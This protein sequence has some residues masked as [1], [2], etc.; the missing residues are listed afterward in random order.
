[1]KVERQCFNDRW[2]SLVLSVSVGKYGDKY[3]AHNDEN[4]NN[5]ELMSQANELNKIRCLLERLVAAYPNLAS[6][7]NE[8]R[9]MFFEMRKLDTFSKSQ[10]SMQL[11]FK[12]LGTNKAD[13]TKFASHL[14]LHDLSEFKMVEKPRRK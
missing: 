3:T 5:D 2:K 9:K 11:L 13:V 1:M 8:V 4:A 10:Q 12:N 7:K 6:H 14:Q